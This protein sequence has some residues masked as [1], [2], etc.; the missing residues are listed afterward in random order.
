LTTISARTP[1][2]AIAG[3]LSLL[4][5]DKMAKRSKK[6][7]ESQ[8]K[9]Q[10]LVIV[11]FTSDWEQARDYEALL[12]TSEIAAVI[13][14]QDDQLMGVKGFAVMVPEDFLD[15]AHVIIEAQDVYDD[16]YNFASED[17]ADDDF[18]SELFEDDF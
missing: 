14:E 3:K 5:R 18:D 8:A 9:V 16:F 10:E 1:F 17:E 13:K 7:R 6:S 2:G 12:K 4:R 15:E 11:A